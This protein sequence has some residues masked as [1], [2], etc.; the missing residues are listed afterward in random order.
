MTDHTGT[1]RG[2][3]VTD[4]AA[5]A[6]E[7]FSRRYQRLQSSYAEAQSRTTTTEDLNRWQQRSIRLQRLRNTL[8]ERDLHQLLDA[9]SVLHAEQQLVTERIDSQIADRLR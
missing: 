8:D 5:I 3:K 1:S 7:E 9:N 2:V 6:A 4:P